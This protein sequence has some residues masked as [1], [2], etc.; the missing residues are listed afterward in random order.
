MVAESA[1]RELAGGAENQRVRAEAQ[2]LVAK[3]EAVS[4][5]LAPWFVSGPYRQAGKEAQQLFDVAFAPEGQGTGAA[6]WRP[7][8]ASSGLTN[9][10]RADLDTI[11]AGNHCVIYLKARAFCPRAQAVTLEI[12]SDDGVKVW[13]N[14]TLVHANNAVRG[15]T[16][17]EDKAKGALQEGWNEFLVKITQHTAGCAAAVRVRATDGQAIPGLRVEAGE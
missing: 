4:G 9:F 3:L 16:P 14:R 15:F 5:Y 10:W 8:P 12:G 17:G 2:A 7:L 11:V 6:E 13:I 1:L